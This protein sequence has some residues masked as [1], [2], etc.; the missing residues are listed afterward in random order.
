[1]PEIIYHFVKTSDFRTVLAHGVIGGIFTTDGQI[2]MTFFTER[3]PLPKQVLM[4]FDDNTR[5]LINQEISEDSKQGI[6]REVSF[7]IN[8]NVEVAKQVAGWLL[9]QIDLFEKHAA[10][11][12]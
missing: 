1:M 11:N 2:N 7:G 3:P 12:D 4:R 5:Q 9:N 6:I 10:V 8:M